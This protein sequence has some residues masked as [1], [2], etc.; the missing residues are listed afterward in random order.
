M[1]KEST[2]K[3]GTVT[4]DGYT[5]PAS[6]AQ[7]RLWFLDQLQHRNS[8]YN[9][10]STC[11]LKGRLNVSAF[12][13]AVNE[14][15]Q[16]H[17]VLRTNF[18]TVEGT[19]FQIIALSRPVTIHVID[20]CR[21]KEP[22]RES[23]ALAL[24]LEESQRP[25]DLRRGP[26]LRVTLLRLGVED[27]V[28]LIVMHHIASDGWS[29]GVFY[30][31]LGTLYEAA[32]AGQP[33][34]LPEL[35]IQYA[36]FTLWQQQLVQGE[37]LKEHLAYWKKQL[38]GAPEVLELSGDYMRPATQ[39]FHGAMCSLELD[40]SLLTELKGLSR[41][42]DATL[43]MTLLASFHLLL[44]RYTGQQDIVVGSPIAGR[45]QIQVQEL[46]GFFVNTLALRVTFAGNPA[47]RQLLRR[48]KETALGAYA[49]QE[50]PFE[51]L[52]E[53]LQ[54]RRNLSYTPVFQ[55]F[56]NL[57]D[58]DGGVR[59][60][61]LEVSDYALAQLDSKFD[62]TLYVVAGTGQSRLDVVYNRDLFSHAR[63]EE[64]LKQFVY[65]LQQI[66]R[67]P[68]EA[69][70]NFSLRTCNVA[71]PDPEAPLVYRWSECI[72]SRFTTKAGACGDSV[73]VSDG[74]DSWTYRELEAR[75]NQLA[76]C[77]R[78]RGIQK[79]DVVAIYGDRSASLVWAML[80][81]LKAGAAFVMLD[82]AY[83]ASRL[84]DQI[85]LTEPKAWIAIES[86][87]GTPEDFKALVAA[88][89]CSLVL[90]LP[91]RA[92]AEARG[93]FSEH[94][95]YPPAVE[96]CGEDLAYVVFTSG[97]TGKPNGVATPH[98]SLSHFLTW[99]TETFG[100]NQEDQFSLLSGLS[101]DPLLR[102]VF[103][104]LWVGATLRIPEPETILAPKHLRDWMRAE[105]ISVA[106]CTPG[107]LALLT[108]GLKE[109]NDMPLDRLRYVFAGGDVL[110]RQR[111][112]NLVG[113]APH[114]IC[115]NFYGTSETPQAMA[116]YL[117]GDPSQNCAA[118]LTPKEA[119]PIGPGISDV[120]LLIVNPAGQLAGTGELGE[121]YIRT[122]YL[123]AG[124]VNNSQLTKQ[125]FILNPFTGSTDDRVYKTGDLA[126]YLPDGNVE[127]HG[128]AD[129]QFKIR[130]FRVEVVEIEST[131]R[132]HTNVREAVVCAKDDASGNKLLVAY[133][134]CTVEGNQKQLS[135]D[136]RRLVRAQL[137]E[138][139][140]PAAFVVLN[141][142]PLTPNNKVDYA[143]L[144]MPG[145]VHPPGEATLALP[146]TNLEREI[147]SIWHEAL[148]VA[149]V[150]VEE[151]FFDLGG[152]S[153]LL[154]KVHYRLEQL[155][156]KQIPLIDLFRY[157][158]VALLAEYLQGKENALQTAIAVEAGRRGR[159]AASSNRSGDIAIIGMAGRF[160]GAKDIS[161]YWHNLCGGVESIT[162]FSDAEIA[163]RGVDAEMLN[164]PHYVKAGA[165]LDGIEQF[166]AGFFGINPREAELTDPQHRL[167]LESAWSAF[168][169]AGYN[170]EKYPGSVGVFGGASVNTYLFGNLL[171]NR[172]LMDLLGFSVSILHGNEKDY[173]PARISYKLGLRGP[174]MA[175]Q[176]ACSTSLV[177][178]SRACQS[179]LNSECDMALAGGVSVNVWQEHG[180]LYEGDSILSP[181][182]H[183]RAFDAR[184][185]G[186]I[187]GSG[188][189]LVVLKRLED[190]MADGDHLIA[191]IKGFAINNDGALRVGFTAPSVDGQAA[192]IRAA[193][194][195]AGVE[196]ET[197]TYVETHGTGT[198]LGDPVEVAALTQAFR[199]GTEKKQFCAIGSVKT[200]VGHLNAAA[201][202][203]GLI[204]AALAV[205]YRLIPPSL[206]YEQPNPQI[207]FFGGPFYVNTHLHE[208]N[209]PGPRRAGVSSFGIG[210]TN[211]HVVLEEAPPTL[212][213]STSRP[214]QLLVM[215]A[216]SEEAL[217][218]MGG[219]LR[220][221]LRQDA[222]LELAD[223][224][225]TLAAGRNEF[226]YRQ[227]V[228]CRSKEEAEEKL[229]QNA[230]SILRGEAKGPHTPLALLF[231]GQGSQYVK[232]GWELY[233]SEPVFRCE[234]DRSSEYLKQL[235]GLDLRQAMFAD[236]E[237]VPGA[238]ELLGQTWITQPA[239]YVLELALMKLWESWGVKCSAML[240]HSLG[241]LVAATAAGVLSSED[242]LRLVAERGRLMWQTEPG[243][244]VAVALNEQAAL[245]YVRTGVS[246][247]AVN[248]RTQVVFSG[249][250][251]EIA[252]LENELEQEGIGARRLDVQRAF[253]SEKMETIR[254]EFLKIVTTLKL[255]KPV[256]RYISNVSGT[257]AG[258]EVTQ[259][260]YWWK[261]I[262]N[263]VQ[264]SRGIR[265]LLKE[266][267]WAW[268]EVGPGEALTRLVR[269]GLQAAKKEAVVLPSLGREENKGK[270]Q[271]QIIHA[272]G[273]LWVNGV[274]VDWLGYYHN[275]RRQRVPLPTYPFQRQKYWIEPDRS[276]DTTRASLLRKKSDVADWFY[277]P[278]WKRSVSLAYVDSSAPSSRV[279]SALVF[280]DEFGVGEAL[281][282]RLRLAGERAIVIRTSEEFES[283]GNDVYS[284]NPRQASHYSLLFRQLR[285]SNIEPSA[286]F[287][288]WL[289]SADH[290]TNPEASVVENE[291]YF[292]FYSLLFLAQAQAEF[293]RS[294]TLRILVVVNDL[295]EVNGNETR[296][297]A[298]AT[299][300][301]PCR[302]IPQEHAYVSV[303]C[304]DV[305]SAESQSWQGLIGNLLAEAQAD[306]S[307]VVVAYRNGYRWVQTFE[308]LRL[309]ST[310]QSKVNDGGVYLIT[311]GMGGMGLALAE[312]LTNLARVKLVL[313]GR[314]AFPERSGWEIWL[315]TH[316]PDDDT[317]RKISKLLK[318]ESEGAEVMVCRADVTDCE[319]MKRVIAEVHAR[320]GRINGVIHAAGIAGGGLIELKSEA[321]AGHV[322]SP[323]LKGTLTLAASLH[324]ENLDFF[325]L[326]SS[327]ASI[328]GG[329]GQVDYCAANNFLDAFAQYH[330]RQSGIFTVSINW[331]AWRDEGM[332][333]NTNLP[334]DMEFS[335]R[336]SLKF[337]IASGE[338]AD[339]FDRILSS[340]LPQVVVSPQD[341]SALAEEQRRR[342]VEAGQ[343]GAKNTAGQETISPASLLHDRPAITAVYRAPGN[344]LEQQIAALWEQFL[345]ITPV[346]ADD[347]FL[348]LGGHSLLAT[349]VISRLRGSLGVEISLRALFQNPTVAALATIVAKSRTERSRSEVSP[350]TRTVRDGELP[351][352]FAQH[353]LWMLDQLQPGTSAYN[354]FSAIR[355]TGP[356]N[357]DALQN[358]LSEI[359]RRHE[360]L[361]T[362]FPEIK[363]HA[364]QEISAARAQGL[365]MLDL[366]EC[367]EIDRKP[368]LMELVNE[369]AQR[370][371]NLAVGPLFRTHLLRLSDQE[372]VLQITLH[373][374]VSDGWSTGVLLR[375]I[376]AL[377][378][379]R[380]VGTEPLL[381]EL[382][383]QY[384]DYAQ[385]QREW[386]SGEVRQSQLAYWMEQLKQAP[387]VLQLPTDHARLDVQ[388]M[389]GSTTSAL[390]KQDLLNA[391]QELGRRCG[392]TLFMVLL[393]AF[394]VLLGR[395]S[396]QTD[397]VVGS[398]IAGRNRP[399]VEG[400]V[401]FFVNTLVLRT[402]LEGD[403]SFRELVA[404]VREV[405]LSAY[406][407]QDLPFEM[408]VDELEVERNLSRSPLFQVVFVL[409]NAPRQ[410]LNLQELHVDYLQVESS[411][412][413]FD[414]TL[415]MQE[416]AE[417]LQTWLEYNNDLFEV[418]TIQRMMGHLET[419]LAGIVAGPDQRISQFPLVTEKERQELLGPGGPL[420]DHGSSDV[421]ITHWFE[422]QAAHTPEAIAISFGDE[423]LSYQ[424]LNRRSNQL[425]HHLRS[426]GVSVGDRVGICLERSLE[427]VVSILGVLKA[428]GAYVP[429]DPAYPVERINFIGED[430]GAVA[431][432]SQSSIAGALEQHH[433]Q[434][435]NWDTDAEV[436]ARQGAEHFE[437]GAG[438][439][440]VAYVIYTSGST[441][442]PK[443]VLVTHHN[444]IRLL[445]ATENWFHFDQHDVWTLFH[446]YAFDFS[447]WEIW[448]ALLYGGRLVVVPYWVSRT[449]E[450]FYQLLIE[451]KV[452]VLNQTPSAFRQL[453][454][455][456]MLSSPA[457]SPLQLRFV[458]FGGEALALNI[459]QPW[460][461]HHG[462]RHPQ[463]I[464]MYGITETTVHVTFRPITSAD[465]KDGTK[466]LIGVPIPDL[467]TYLLDEQMQP[468]PVGVPG[469][470]FVGGA[471]L[472]LGYLNRPE[473]TAQHFVP[474]P[475]SG[476]PGAR[477]YRSGDLARRLADQDVEYLGRSDLQVKIRGF[478]I[479]LGE[480]ESVLTK[481]PGVGKAIVVA[482]SDGEDERQLVA[483]LVPV[484]GAS[485]NLNEMR[486]YLKDNL[487]DYMV[488]AAYVL[489][490]EIPLTPHGKIDQPALPEPATAAIRPDESYMPPR[491]FIERVLTEIWSQVLGVDQVG[492]EDNFFALG[493]DSI[494]SIQVRAQAREEGLEFSLQ[495]L[496][497]HPTVQKL[498]AQIAATGHASRASSSQ[499]LFDLLPEA[500][501]RLLPDE[502]EDAYP[503]TMLQT[504]MVFYSELNRDSA[505]YHDIFSYYIK[506]PF[507]LEKL[508]AAVSELIARHP[509]LR[510]SFDLKRYGTPLQL[511][512]R[513]ASAQVGSEDLCGL[514]DEEQERG[515]NVWI[516]QEKRR[517]FEWSSAP[518]FRLQIHRRSEETLQLSLSFHHAILDGWSV[519]SLLTEML[520]LYWALLTGET[521]RFSPPVALFRD[522]VAL[523]TAILQSPEA[524]TFWTEQ[525]DGATAVRLPRLGATDETM[526]PRKVCSHRVAI[527]AEI[528]NGLKELARVSATPIKSVLLAAH[529]RVMSRL[530]GQQ[531]VISGLVANGRPEKADGDRVLGL[532]LNTLPMRLV[533]SG[534][535]WSDLVQA[536]FAAEKRMLPF[537]RFPLAQIQKMNEGLPLFETVFNFIHFHVYQGLD[538]LPGLQVLDAKAFEETN[539]SLVA[540]FSLAGEESQVHLNLLYN[541]SILSD[542][543]VDS[544]GDYY[545][546]A[547]TAMA[548]RPKERYEFEDLL[549]LTERQRLLVLWKQTRALQ[550]EKRCLHQLFEGRAREMPD[551]IAVAA[552]HL[553][554]TYGELDRRTNQLAR[555][556]KGLGIGPEVTVGVCVENGAEMV[557]S[558]LAILKAGGAYMPMDVANPPERRAFM[559]ENS[560]APVLLTQKKFKD[561]GSIG[562]VHTV[563]LDTDGDEI[564]AG[565]DLPVYGGAMPGNIAYTIYTSGS[566]GQPK[567]VDVT[568]AGLLNL[569]GWHQRTYE[570][571]KHD[572]AS[573]IASLGFDASVW[574]MWPYLAAGSSLHIPDA[575]TRLSIKRLIQWFVQEEITIGFLPTPLAELVIHEEEMLQATHLRVLLTGGDRLRSGPRSKLPFRLMNH[576]GP[577]ENSVVAT[578]AEVLEGQTNPPI[579]KPVSNVQ[580]YVLDSHMLPV[581]AGVPGEL[582]VTGDSLA[583]G[584]SRDPGQT[585]GKFVPDQFSRKAGSRLYRTGDS[586]RWLANGQLEFLGRMDQQVKIRGHRIEL[587]EVEATLRVQEDV[588][589]VV[590]AAHQ[591]LAGDQQLVAYVVAR[592]AAHRLGEQLAACVAE[593]L[594]EYMVPNIFIFVDA[595]PLTVSGKLDRKRLPAPDWQHIAS[596]REFVAPRTP[597]EAEVARIWADALGCRQISIYDNFFALGGDSL[598][599]IRVMS[600]LNDSLQIDLPLR[601]L[602]DAPEVESFVSTIIQQEAGNAASGLVAQLLA[603]LDGVSEDEARSVL[604]GEIGDLA[605]V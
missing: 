254:E 118:E 461:A 405:C 344:D 56:F 152:N 236:G 82:P 277:V 390:L 377:Y 187:F 31:E 331:G 589:D 188:V 183:C 168:E 111:V 252:E 19:L 269:N 170:P 506:L 27:H 93:M 161:E 122:P 128:R 497:Q 296:S 106:H 364:V 477:L 501:R 322:I 268:L 354:I 163:S 433:G 218:Q 81:V 59:L 162:F 156:G 47:F 110:T 320:F 335:R 256:K 517:P 219:N 241:E 222:G 383:V 367:P 343:A 361:R 457:S 431:I 349:Q 285:G 147:A 8:A 570:I 119:V 10:P 360:S 549:S 225:Y 529:L 313:S 528:S 592:D 491:T 261:Q 338:G 370:S 321:M 177:A 590:V 557:V 72:P 603:E 425:A 403:P 450:A 67:N 445:R 231:S 422:A 306:T 599:A 525:L 257:W 544:M 46:I 234:I 64:M 535:T 571:T 430:V 237:D 345:G 311:G 42:E 357:V 426:I 11:R 135:S 472:A 97:T 28:L 263:P 137:P 565:S 203:S 505:I 283:L 142:L 558:A 273:N 588:R 179:L 45:N 9:I 173:L 563:C 496:F 12:E 253:H 593:R 95:M 553:R 514:V 340:S 105:Q 423:K 398:P 350:L 459:L 239:L 540:N 288:L 510:T 402:D 386:L 486:G 356:L 91:G 276:G 410:A 421:S 96:I 89:S 435:V 334:A 175:V 144:P 69:T 1:M 21:E 444:V 230:H 136:L 374:I 484:P 419:L 23:R 576:Y 282:T 453:I 479:E 434:V 358:A 120:Q 502:V 416:T 582:Y 17:E 14:I 415:T 78:A 212:P 49:H 102:D 284:I 295:H 318:L 270:E 359:V 266:E 197:I 362:T 522:Y 223:V 22:Q 480:I 471:G 278:S 291:Q 87:S 290:N 523:E 186:T 57:I 104:P 400:L 221:H 260:D 388:S 389:R 384:A 539:F 438:K 66:A 485:L 336:E 3:Q 94:S 414:L 351:L 123:A 267:G 547:L 16:R 330:K 531:D 88:S 182:G 249:G 113:L 131:L 567:G 305:S 412:A 369:E 397:I 298:K 315:R 250:M 155:T 76:H 139:M 466:S 551:Q 153:L 385:W 112:A 307:D 581:A 408:L 33:S 63:M 51:K 499:Q 511:V 6:Y 24:A 154:V 157:P 355:L 437:T 341:L 449:P 494:R 164:D 605:K 396:G 275:E 38:E 585:A 526:S 134:V 363:G 247:A 159:V 584:Y 13:H 226:R 312:H 62:F 538:K 513:R 141:T 545:L 365:P 451:Q 314:S 532:F 521:V 604:A 43:F 286:V 401:G 48:V 129:R 417:G 379:A 52:V 15:V 376:A 191:V 564:A 406:A 409:Q 174:S 317:S 5:F 325:A 272:L 193:M 329:T 238:T 490:P 481:H 530:S 541:S 596:S 143:A 482:R 333:V 487:P 274:D 32:C 40:Q 598:K 519:A 151:N 597:M 577:T 572:R 86:S 515:V 190:A 287:H 375:E 50:L 455:A 294:S 524:Q 215:S 566:T 79:Q 446:S 251:R 127:L 552:A 101:H 411:T 561:S 418:A 439:N 337:A 536:T 578:W 555:Y 512:H 201:G 573:Q 25:F 109:N 310:E 492:I 108:E 508:R 441:G 248:G 324:D 26:L 580:A 368:R 467:R 36:D 167:F 146:R 516:E 246:L 381:A 543:Q 132:G 378:D 473:L 220:D 304:I 262:R 205:K 243:A 126:R 198:P 39:T 498:A 399:E 75:S 393:A 489:I 213:G 297:P 2:I 464:N 289:L 124:Y 575:E 569:V 55:F 71:L 20:L 332:A 216:R 176:T 568:H 518:L 468:V 301:G 160:P 346:G 353:R 208:W 202:V 503:L 4:K 495:Q 41:E 172:E 195:S 140:V 259:P 227:A 328:L 302:V 462:D 574:E 29:M 476:T 420:P 537:R 442:K 339:A 206:H 428:G 387:A 454:Q 185:Q 452:T 366:S 60:S 83:P 70:A 258:D 559:L 7:Q 130:G 181:D 244:M 37:F 550:I 196:P 18:E 380:C 98:A 232:M 323:K 432:I 507:H 509:I 327:R 299:V 148:P 210:G 493:G 347:D 373:H 474:D 394:K 158:T 520:Q 546:R 58:F 35:P 169:S 309:R 280:M 209:P 192:V 308:P 424:E 54:L 427:M 475:F 527:P 114:V 586:V 465:L 579:G 483:Y 348:E 229:A 303:R 53:G 556:L 34:P 242:G 80:S 107:L 207:D 372:H 382:P 279:S 436:I 391:L 469:E 180:Y 255:N 116:H 458:I 44:H 548:E 133:I 233:E 271:D 145:D 587:G 395:Y 85:Q 371:F 149:E 150:G 595:L 404:R 235:I 73:A 534:G 352:S 488:P 178:V 326:C 61:G 30:G 562:T 199:S 583:R 554:L 447:V 84:I 470:I 292:G 74:C 594:P 204:K 171:A 184:A 560:G 443:G 240:G 138:Y 245:K 533:L 300:L 165:V 413:K 316:R 319:E 189:G 103:A 542:D 264:F 166:D 478:R 429:M 121:V 265:E 281:V 117:V 602:F 601:T 214:L 228:L 293:P 77:L 100:L 456:D 591:D 92:A 115:V 600:R 463:L 224:A 194:A 407:H 440:D 342:Q 200:N 99:H 211:A 217:R 392:A 460:F 448:G 90:S 65:L 68:D 504:G 500:D 125:R